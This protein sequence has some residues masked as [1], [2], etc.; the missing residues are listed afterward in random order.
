M[1]IRSQTQLHI[2]QPSKL[3]GVKTVH[4]Q[5]KTLTTSD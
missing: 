1:N 5:A 2:I 4:L 3:F